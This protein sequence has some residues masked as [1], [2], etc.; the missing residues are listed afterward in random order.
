ME[1]ILSGTYNYSSNDLI[2]FSGSNFTLRTTSNTYTG[3]YS[4]SGNALTL[5]GHGSTISWIRDTWIITDSNTL[6][7]SDGDLWIRR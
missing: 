1:F 5:S 4:V 2:T 6:R 3:T 7:D